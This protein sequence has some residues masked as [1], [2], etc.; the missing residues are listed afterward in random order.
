[1]RPCT[2]SCCSRNQLRP[3]GGFSRRKETFLGSKTA[4][5]LIGL[6]GVDIFE[7]VSDPSKAE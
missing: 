4:G 1:M 3:P 5:V 7:I 2:A 6:G